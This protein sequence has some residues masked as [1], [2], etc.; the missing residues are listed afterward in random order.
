MDK[1]RPRKLVVVGAGPVGCLAALAFAKLG[2]DVEL[3]EGRPG[4]HMLSTGQRACR[5]GGLAHAVL[6]LEDMRDPA[7]KANLS[8]RSINLAISSRG[9]SALSVVDPN[10]AARFMENVVPVHGRMIHD[11]RGRCESQRYDPNGQCINSIDRGLLNIGLLD[12][13]AQYSNLR[14]HFHTKLTTVDF[15]ERVANFTANGKTFDVHFDLCIGA[16][17]SYSNVRRQLMRVVR[18]VMDYQQEY[19]PH[20]Y[21]ELSIPPGSDSNGDPTFLLDPNHLHIWPRH[22]F[23]LIAL[24]NK[25]KSFTCTL[26]APTKELDELDTTEKF[27]TW[28]ETHFCDAVD[29]IGRSRLAASFERNPRNSLICVKTN[30]YHYKDRAIIIGDAAH[31]MTPF[32]GQGLN[33]GLED[34]RVLVNTFKTFGVPP[35]T[36]AAGPHSEDKQLSQ[37]LAYYSEHRHQDL[38]AICDLAMGNYVEM[39]HSVTTPVY[40][41][42]KSIDAFLSRFTPF[43]PWQSLIPVLATTTF[44]PGAAKGWISL[45]TMVTFRPDIS[46]ATAQRK[47]RDQARRVTVAL[48]LVA[49]LSLVVFVFLLRTIVRLLL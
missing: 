38:V 32:Y 41:L 30:P 36:S 26:F 23:M 10:I 11:S 29:H 20:D 43:V 49:V 42:R 45:Y 12:E 13:L 21:I 27:V 8:L 17:G 18:Q 3:F 40:R 48:R 15:D 28:F 9:I 22:S 39:R 19:L 35:T 33:C 2:W 44:P 37:A 6:G 34:V 4:E 16:D 31:A 5:D 7:V 46:Y 25:N 14:I 47:A 24:P 1:Q